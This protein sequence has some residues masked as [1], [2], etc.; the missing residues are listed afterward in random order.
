LDRSFIVEDWKN[1]KLSSCNYSFQNVKTSP[2]RRKSRSILTSKIAN[3]S[4]VEA[5]RK[6]LHKSTME[7]FST[8]RGRMK[9]NDHYFL[10]KICINLHKA[11][12]DENLRIDVEFH[13][14]SLRIFTTSEVINSSEANHAKEFYMYKLIWRI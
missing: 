11:R 1:M 4:A 13:L 3:K 10:F 5:S 8:K 14:L 2:H 6:I 9:E 12:F 7:S